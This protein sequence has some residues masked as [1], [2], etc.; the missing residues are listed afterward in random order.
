[1]LL[2]PSGAGAARESLT[3]PKVAEDNLL[4]TSDLELSRSIID[5]ISCTLAVL[6]AD[7]T[8]LMVNRAWERF[9]A[10]NGAS[11]SLIV[12]VGLSYFDMCHRSTASGIT[13]V[14]GLQRVLRGEYPEFTCLYPCHSPTQKRWMKM[15]AVSLG[16]GSQ[17]LMLRHTNVSDAYLIEDVLQRMT[18][19]V[20]QSPESVVIVDANGAIEYLNPG[21]SD[22]SGY[23]AIDMV[24]RNFLTWRTAHLVAAA[25]EA[26]L[27]ALVGRQP[28]S[29]DLLC[30]HKSG[31]L[32]W[33]QVSLWPIQ[34]YR[35]GGS[36]A[37]YVIISR[38]ITE[39]KRTEKEILEHK[40]ALRE[41]Y[42]TVL[43]VR[44]EERRSIARDLH[45]DMGQALT[46]LRMDVHQLKN[47]LV[48]ADAAWPARLSNM[49]KVVN[50]NID[51]VGRV[52]E[53][54]RPGMLDILGLAAAIEHHVTNYARHSGLHCV[55]EMNR[56][57]FSTDEPTAITVFR[58]IQ[59]L[60]TNVSRHA[61]A[62]EVNI[63]LH[64]SA[65]ILRLQFSDNGVGISGSPSGGRH[66]FGL[67]GIG[68]R[69]SA[70]SGSTKIDRPPS[71]GL[72]VAITLPLVVCEASA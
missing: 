23:P 65:G 25:P 21:F 53:N 66:R 27:V 69:V 12:G 38:N 49:L 59:E 22:L 2:S 24:G 32:Y 72:R 62:S 40:Q 6:D 54:L 63:V 45:D 68:E 8:I 5:A 7:G 10:E 46:V 43:T 50:Q 31:E 64:E 51:V 34:D 61:Q 48:G 44:E 29:G 3:I 70:L 55:L 4:D 19:V 9:G 30:R 41:L 28:W 17:A 18:Q 58:I 52:C 67:L 57:D 20:E 15:V 16:H 60:L 14:E 47:S 11:A 56:E 33:E 26:M 42:A 37:G 71:G 35:D 13:Q 39:Q 36:K 1:M